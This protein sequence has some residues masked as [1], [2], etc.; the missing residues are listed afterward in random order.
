MLESALHLYRYLQSLLND[1]TAARV[2]GA[3]KARCPSF[4]VE[5]H[6]HVCMRVHAGVYALSSL[7]FTAFGES[8]AG[9]LQP[10]PCHNIIRDLRKLDGVQRGAAS[11]IKGLGGIKGLIYEER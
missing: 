5:Q 4:Q 3:G 8:A 9:A 6:V 1:V 10:A 11:T 2:L 7:T